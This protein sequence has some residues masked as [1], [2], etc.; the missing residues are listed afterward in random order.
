MSGLLD[1]HGNVQ[2][3]PFGELGFPGDPFRF[4]GGHR[5]V[6]ADDLFGEPAGN[7]IAVF[8]MC[9]NGDA[10]SG[11]DRPVFG[12]TRGDF[13]CPFV[14]WG[15][16]FERDQRKIGRVCGAGREGDRV[17]HREA[18]RCFVP[19]ACVFI[20]ADHL[21]GAGPGIGARKVERV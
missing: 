11:T 2:C 3:T 5:I 6:F 16:V 4:F 7:G 10:D 12:G 17:G 20:P 13:D 18:V 9:R 21:F 8:I 19:G 14:D 1:R 15:P